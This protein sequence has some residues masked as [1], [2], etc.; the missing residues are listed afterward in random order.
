MSILR[1]VVYRLKRMGPMTWGTPQVRGDEGG[2]TTADVRDEKSEVN[3]WR[4]R[5][6][7]PNEL[8]RW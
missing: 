3:H 7:I 8:E 6:E 5:E 1:G 4:E 2:I